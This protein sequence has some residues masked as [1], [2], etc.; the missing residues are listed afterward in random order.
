MYRTVLCRARRFLN[1]EVPWLMLWVRWSEL[2]GCGFE[3]PE[4]IARS[5]CLGDDATVE[6]PFN[7]VLG[8][9]RRVLDLFDR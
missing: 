4:A 6:R 2:F 7:E 1:S 9:G 5:K 8:Q 3:L